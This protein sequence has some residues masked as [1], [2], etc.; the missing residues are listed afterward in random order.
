MLS[1]SAFVGRRVL[2][3]PELEP[4]WNQAERRSARQA[5]RVRARGGLQRRRL[6][7]RRGARCR[8]PRR[9]GRSQRIPRRNTR[10]PTRT[11]VA[12]TPA[13]VI[14]P[15]WEN[16]LINSPARGR[17]IGTHH[18]LSPRPS[19]ALHPDTGRMHRVGSRCVGASPGRPGC[20]RRRHG[21]ALCPA[22]LSAPSARG[23]RPL[24]HPPVPSRG[25]P[26]PR[27]RP[28]RR[29]RAPRLPSP[30][31]SAPTCAAAGPSTAACTSGASSA[32][33]TRSWPSAAKAGA[34][35]PRAGAAA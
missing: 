2:A 21:P 13:S 20:T 25:L 35:A 27:F 28:R 22:D 18:D 17:G 31:N 9:P 26:G 5:R 24:S 16:I 34:S 30:A 10:P 33:M 19:C 15:P 23:H 12:R 14:A 7:A 11:A 6:L 4:T 29:R 3:G 32:T 1:D 8:S